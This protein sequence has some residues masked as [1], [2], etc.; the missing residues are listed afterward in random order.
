MKLNNYLYINIILDAAY[1]TN[2][3]SEQVDMVEVKNEPN[4]S[5]ELFSICKNTNMV[6]NHSRQDE[7]TSESKNHS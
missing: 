7:V 5:E 4:E 1:Y 3:M 6:T 2:I